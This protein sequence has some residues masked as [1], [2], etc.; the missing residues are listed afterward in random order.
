[1]TSTL[2]VSGGRTDEIRVSGAPTA[3]E[4]AAVLA[5]LCARD[6]ADDDVSGYEKWRRRRLRA[7]RPTV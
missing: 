7:L 2:R 1:M 4:L 6:V 5:T 3:H